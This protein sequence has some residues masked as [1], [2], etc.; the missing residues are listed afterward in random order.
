M[1]A[2]SAVFYGFLMGFVGVVV[3]FALPLVGVG[4]GLWRRIRQLEEQRDSL[5][6]QLQNAMLELR[7]DAVLELVSDSEDEYEEGE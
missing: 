3:C 2:D 1:T 6:L 4:F 7:T 5:A